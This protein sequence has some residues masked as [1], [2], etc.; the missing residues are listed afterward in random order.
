MN[1]RAVRK[2]WKAAM[3]MFAGL[4]GLLAAGM[5]VD[6]TGLTRSEAADDHDGGEG[7]GETSIPIEGTPENDII[8]GDGDGHPA[9][10]LIL[11]GDGDDQVNGYAGNDTLSGEGGDDQLLGDGGDDSLDGGTGDDSLMGGN[12]A[13]PLAGGAGDDSLAGQEG[14]DRLIGGEG[15]D[16]LNGGG[17]E[18]T[19]NG[20][21][22]DDALE[23]GRGDDDL[24]GGAGRDTLMGGEGRDRL[25]GGEAPG[26]AQERDFL[27]GGEGDDTLSAGA[28]DWA[29]GGA[30]KDQFAFA[31]YGGGDTGTATI[32][33]Y[34]PAE[35]QLLLLYDPAIHPDPAVT[36]EPPETEGGAHRILIDGIPVAQVFGAAR[37]DPADILVR[38]APA[39]VR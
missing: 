30:G 11:A 31:G 34:D 23:G 26:E 19:L 2:K 6:F 39:P 35:D 25:D 24:S 8:S 29:T 7:E 37:I 21:A 3:L 27:N 17:D 16:S 22:G 1:P 38:P 28:G 4:L 18:D 14:D 5:S 36:V 33:D 13:D 15:D 9:D 12:G 10:D 20:G 32:G